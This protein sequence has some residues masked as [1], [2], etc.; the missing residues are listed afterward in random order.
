MYCCPTYLNA[1]NYRKY[2]VCSKPQKSNGEIGSNSM[3]SDSIVSSNKA[4]IQTNSTKRKNQ[5][6]T[7]KSKILVKSKNHDFPPN[8]RHK[9]ARIG[10]FTP[11][12][13]LTFTQLRQVFVEAPILYY[14]DLE[15][16]IWIKTDALNYAISNVLS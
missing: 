10:F 9:E 15:S 16:H 7:I 8:F 1:K 13:R 2:W 4:T 5:V 3:D 14:F 12:A 6:K 11:K